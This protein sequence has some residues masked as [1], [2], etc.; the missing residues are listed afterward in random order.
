MKIAFVESNT[1]G[2]GMRFLEQA[3]RMGL[4]PVL[5]ATKPEIYRSVP[6]GV[7]VSVVDTLSVEAMADRCRAT[8]DLAAICTSSD[9]HLPIAAKLASVLALPGPNPAGTEHAANKRRQRNVLEQTNVTQ[10]KYRFV[11]TSR[12]AVI[13]H[14]EIFCGRPVV[15]KPVNGSGK[16]GVRL[17]TTPEEVK[18]HAKILA[19]R[20][21]NQRGAPVS[22]GFLIEEFIQGSEF[23]VEVFD[24]I[25]ICVVQKKS[26]PPCFIEEGHVCPA[27][28][29]PAIA[30]ALQ[31]AAAAAAHAL[32]LTWGPIHVEIKLNSD[33]VCYLI[34]VNPRLAGG[35]I[36]FLVKAALGIDLID[37]SLWKALDK[38][39]CLLPTTK[40][41]SAIAFRFLEHEGRV[42]T[43]TGVKDA[44]SIEAIIEAEIYLG[45]GETFVHHNDFRD[46][47][48]HVISLA[49]SATEATLLAESAVQKLTIHTTK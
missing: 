28:I 31:S 38:R 41:S 42:R 33:G 21:V 20:R 6:A 46:R 44:L 48:G 24:G 19:E 29:E 22:P 27:P 4:T 36:P 23:S 49:D 8:A 10:P 12:E 47:V 15:L 16:V 43:I 35:F 34:E 5:L 30:A 7:C 45:I 37:A 18:S 32:A 39:V 25:P 3:L 1:T 2:T 11:E 13:L 9:Y 40:K 17:A 26:G 14:E